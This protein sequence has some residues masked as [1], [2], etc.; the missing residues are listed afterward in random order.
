MKINWDICKE[1]LD[2][3]DN[4]K[5][6]ELVRSKENGYGGEYTDHFG[7]L[8]GWGYVKNKNKRDEGRIVNIVLTPK[9]YELKAILN[10]K[11]IYPR[12]KQLSAKL[13]MEILPV[14]IDTALPI[15]IKENL[16]D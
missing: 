9:G 4:D 15:I 11:I 2:A 14:L 12:L 5:I 1:I 8:N 3:V 13:D 6:T 10:S 7:F 16:E